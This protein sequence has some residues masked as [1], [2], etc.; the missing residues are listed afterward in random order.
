MQI[1]SESMEKQM[2]KRPNIVIINPDEMRWDTMGHMGNPAASTPNLDD[3]ARSEAVSF[4]N[5]F[6]FRNFVS[7]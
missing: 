1:R 6:F 2:N 5:A 3:F 7:H 4:E